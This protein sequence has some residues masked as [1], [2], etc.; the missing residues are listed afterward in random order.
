[1]SVR[2]WRRRWRGLATMVA[3]AG[4]G[5]G[6]LVALDSLDETRPSTPA[7]GLTPLGG[8]AAFGPTVID[9]ARPAASEAGVAQGPGEPAKTQ[10]SLSSA[11]G[12]SPAFEEVELEPPYLIVDGRSLTAGRWALSLTGIETPQRDAVC[13]D[14]ADLLFACGLQARA[15]LN[16]LIRKG[17][18]NCT[19]RLPPV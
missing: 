9:P 7:P 10:D 13:F 16:N 1:M 3:V 19:V 6:L 18:V 8:A 2:R 11:A 15:A 17:K 14:R 4:L 12:P 5:A